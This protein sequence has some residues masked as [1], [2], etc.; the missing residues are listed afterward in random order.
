MPTTAFAAQPGIRYHP[1]VAAILRNPEG[2]IL[3]CERIDAAGAWQFPQGGVDPGET[4]EEALR[5][6]VWEEISVRDGYTISARRGP[7]RYEYP[8]GG[9]KRGF[10]GKE[11]EYFLLEYTGDPA[12]I[13]LETAHPEFRS[14]R[15]IAPQEF[16]LSWLPNMKKAVYA[17]VLE[18]FFGVKIS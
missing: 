9:S 4:A 5:R 13:N 1:N 3:V 7:Y 10:Q 8:N 18:D 2:K 15:W 17:A 16:Q 14:C 11:Q 12:A 6:E